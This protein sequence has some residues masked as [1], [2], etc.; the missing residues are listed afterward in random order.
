VNYRKSS[1]ALQA[2]WFNYKDAHP[3]AK[4]SLVSFAAGFNAALS[5]VELE[6]HL[7]IVIQLEK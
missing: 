1:K 2:A 7:K 5:S 3:E 4:T 6:S